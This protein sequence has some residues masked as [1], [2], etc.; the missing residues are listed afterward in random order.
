MLMKWRNTFVSLEAGI[1]I[2]LLRREDHCAKLT[3]CARQ[4]LQQDVLHIACCQG[5]LPALTVASCRSPTTL[6]DDTEVPSADNTA[7]GQ[8]SQEHI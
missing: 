8:S 1:V 3:E 2:L 6:I 4:Q 7:Y 5:K